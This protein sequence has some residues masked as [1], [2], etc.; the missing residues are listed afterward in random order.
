MADSAARHV[1]HLRPRVMTPEA[2]APYGKVLDRE[3]FILTSTEFPFFSNVGTLRPPDD[4]ILYINRHHD[5]NQIFSSFGEPM[6]VV[7]AEPGLSAQELHPANIVAFVT[8]GAQA[9]VFHVDTWHLEPRALGTKPIR[10]LNVQASNNRVHTERVDLEP[11]FGYVIGLDVPRVSA[12]NQKIEASWARLERALAS[13]GADRLISPL[14]DGWTIK[15]HLFHLSAWEKS[16]IALLEGQDR[17][18]AMGISLA[19]LPPGAASADTFYPDGL[20][21][22]LYRQGQ[23]RSPE[24][25]LSDLQKTHARTLDVLSR[26]SDRDL[27]R[28]YS[29]YQPGSTED[30]AVVEWIDGNTYDHYDEHSE[31]I[32]HARK[33]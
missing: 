10:A 6:I 29:S 32:E 27:L 18:A 17:L 28:P 30:R 19:A 13:I 21:E 1:V 9:F 8:D 22:L 23:D 12:L 33:S 25:V 20:N 14:D 16:L 15:D 26:L 31:A 5:H 3:Q 2:F 24:D 4:P 7:V 11:T